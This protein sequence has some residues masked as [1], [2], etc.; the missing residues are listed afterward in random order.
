MRLLIALLLI[1]NWCFAQK[2]VVKDDQEKALESVSIYTLAEQNT[3]IGITSENGECSLL[4]D[5][6]SKYLFHLVGYKDLIL[7][8]SELRD[9]RG[10]VLLSQTIT[11]LNEVTISKNNLKLRVKKITYKP[12]ANYLWGFPNNFKITIDKVIAV[13]ITEA[14]YLKQFVLF[15]RRENKQTHRSFQFVIFENNSGKPGKSLMSET[16]I[17]EFIGNKM[18]FN[19]NSLKM[20]LADGSYFFGFETINSQHFDQEEA[21]KMNKGAWVGASLLIKSRLD[22][23]QNGYIRSNLKA[24]NKDKIA[25][26]YELELLIPAVN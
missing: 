7:T 3:L 20:Y 10:L 8:A 15:I 25:M 21:K 2:I 22:E 11:P 14:G 16:V 9:R 24:W 26:Q 12:G 6:S 23:S 13:P 1:G 19:L 17:G 18:V 4:I 5:S